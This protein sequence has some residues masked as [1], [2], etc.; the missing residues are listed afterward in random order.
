MNPS[1]E[2]LLYKAHS[3][4]KIGTWRV[5][6]EDEGHCAIMTVAAAKV[7]GGKEVIT[8]TE[9]AAGKNIGRANETSYLEQAVSEARSKV[10][11]KI[12]NGYT[13]T[14]P[15]E[16]TVATN[17]LGLIKPMLAQPIEKVKQ[18]DYPVMVQPKLDGHRMLATVVD[19]KA[20]LYSRQGKL[21]DV[22]H[23]REK[24]QTLFDR[25]FW[26][27]KTLDGEVYAHGET[28]QT[29]S[30]LVK[31]PKPES[32]KL[33]Y[34][35]YDM[36]SDMTYPD[37]HLE[38]TTLVETLD[39]LCVVVVD[40]VEVDNKEELDSLHAEAIGHGYEGTIVRQ[41]DFPYGVGKRCKSLMKK[42][43]FQDA[44]FE[45]VGLTK[46][47]PNRRQGTEVGI[48]RCKT[49]KGVEFSVTAP[50]DADEKHEHALSGE[51]HI[52]KYLTVQFFNLT[53][54]GCPFHPVALRIRE[55]V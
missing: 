7:I 19:G 32:T 8:E 44:E 30:S 4:G 24:L 55:D 13:E 15:E 35:I 47:K 46:G 33:V 54:D 11:K 23:I 34:H 48:Y 45:I 28:L 52:G 43:D 38:V 36:V 41:S 53:A 5:L 27:G 49:D 26:D 16:G 18:W 29:I 14:K 1:Y 25:G 50:G 20:I 39:E 6:V 10:A 21:L 9:Y 37:R 12:D 3:N 2:Q 31:K 42:K 22:E 51:E 17:G 40:S